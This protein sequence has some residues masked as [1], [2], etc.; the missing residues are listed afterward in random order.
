MRIQICASRRQFCRAAEGSLKF[1]F[2]Q[3]NITGHSYEHG[4]IGKRLCV[5]RKSS[6]LQQHINA[7]FYIVSSTSTP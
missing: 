3:E 4:G 7:V 5:A 1:P 6:F 2:S